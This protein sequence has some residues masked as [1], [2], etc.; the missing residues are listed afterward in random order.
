MWYKRAYP[1]GGYAPL[2]R[3]AWGGVVGSGL[4]FVSANCTVRGQQL[5]VISR[6]S[7]RLAVAVPMALCVIEPVV[8]GVLFDAGQLNK[9]GGLGSAVASASHL[10]RFLLATLAVFAA[11]VALRADVRGAVI[12]PLLARARL[13]YVPLFCHAALLA[14]LF[15]LSRRLFGEAGAT[16]T[17]TWTSVVAWFAAVAATAAT[18]AASVLSWSEWLTLL[19]NA[20]GP[21]LVSIGAGATALLLGLLADRLWWT[22]GGVT[23][24]AV[25]VLLDRVEP[26]VLVSEAK[27]VIGTPRFVVEIS[28]E[29]SGFEGMGLAVVFVGVLLIGAWHALHVARVLAFVPLLLAGVWG[30][31]AVRIAA[32]VWWGA[33]VSPEVALGAFHSKAGWVLFCLVGLATVSLLRSSSLFSRDVGGVSTSP[34]VL[35]ADVADSYN[36]V[37]VYGLPFGLQ[38]LT[39]MIT[40]AFVFHV[41]WLYGVRILAIGAGLYVTR[42]HLPKLMPADWVYP[43]AIG[44]VAFALWMLFEP[45]PDV[46]R[47]ALARAE[48]DAASALQRSV[49][50]VSRC[51]GSAL[52]VPIAEELAFRGF[53]LRRLVAADFEEV[54]FTRW[55]MWS[56][57]ASSFVF[58]ALHDNWIGGVL[59]GVLY[60]YAQKRRGALGDAIVAHAVTNLLVAVAALGFGRWS[61][62]F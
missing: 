21:L 38:L 60:A 4:E 32:L 37:A 26:E 22:L 42:R 57:L 51:V 6:I 36:P 39:G 40:G 13:R 14:A 23:L 27:S 35:R 15:V 31:N 28:P 62:F 29:C 12:A 18:L 34:D 43:T 11:I 33:H 5:A 24:R 20:R 10:L 2:Q 48:L 54:A 58:G 45:A 9:L 17:F 19:R 16:A 59:C 30:L 53:L 50:I 61:L 55:T 49:W 8:F 52:L 56:V 3:T 46:A 47:V 7:P 41:D 25:L 44:V 1:H